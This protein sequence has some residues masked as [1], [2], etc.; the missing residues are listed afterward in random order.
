[1]FSYVSLNT[2]GLR[3]FVKRKSIF[4]FC[5]NERAQCFLLQETHSVDLDEKFWSNQWGDKIIFSHGSNRSAGVAILLNHFPGKILATVRDTCGHW[6]ICVFEIDNHFL[7]LGNIYG[8]NTLNQ[9]KILI[10]EIT[11]V[12]KDLCQRYPTEHL[13]FGGDFNMVMDNWLDRCPSKYSSHH[14]NPLLLGFCSVFK[15]TDIWRTKNP[16]TQIFTWFKP[17]R[18]VKSRIDFWLVSEF[19]SCLELSSIVSAAPLTDHCMVKLV[20]KPVNTYQRTKGYWKFNSNLLNNE[21]FCQD[22]IATISNVIEDSSFTT[23]SKKWEYIKYKVRQISIFYG[24]LLSRNRGKKELEIIKEIN[25]TC[26][27]PLLSEDEKQKIILLQSS[28]DNIFVDKAK[29]AFIRSRAKWI[30]EGERSSTYFCRLEK[31]RQERMSVKALLINNQECTDPNKI[32]KEIFEFY[33]KLY[34]SSYSDTDTDA[35]FYHIK[36]WIPKIDER[37]KD[38]CDADISMDEVEK[39]MKCLPLDKSPGS[40]GLTS[41]FYRHFWEHIKD[42]IFHMLKEISELHI[43]PT[44]MKQ[45]IITL[46]P[47]P[48]KNPKLID[49]LR[50]ITLL[51][52]DYKI[53]THIYANRL[54]TG[55]SQIISETQSGFLKG[56]SIHNNIRLVLDL[57]D[58]S[59]FIEDDGFILF[60]DFFKA[61]DTIEHTFMFRTLELFG[62][63]DNF[64]NMVKLIYKDTNSTV[65][66]PMGT[67]PR[68]SVNKGIKQGCPISPLLFIAAAEMLSILIKNL[69]FEKL[70]VLGKPLAISQLADDTTIFMKNINQIPKILQTIELFS[71]ASGLNLNLKKCE[72]LPIHNSPHSSFC[73]IPIKNTVKYLGIHITKDYNSLS[74]LNICD[75][76]VKCKSLLNLWSQRDISIIGRIFLTKMECIS[77]LVYPAYSLPFSKNE[78]KAINQ[79]IFNFI[80]KGKTHYIRK[81]NLVKDVEEGGLKA[82]DIECINATIKTNWL[83]SFLKNENSF[84]F[85][86]PSQVFLKLGGINLLLRC[87]Y[88]LKKLPVKLSVFH[89]QVLLYWKLIYKH[90]FSPHNVPLWNCRYVVFRNKSIFYKSWWEKGIWSVMHI[91]NNSGVMSFETFCSKYNLYDKKLYDNMIKA[92]P[93]SI[94]QMSQTLSQSDVTPVLPKLLVNGVSLTNLILPNTIIRDAFVK[95]LYPFYLSKQ[96]IFKYFSKTEIKILRTKYFKFPLAPKA[97]EVHFKIINGIYPSREFLSCRFGLEV[98]NCSFCT[99]QIETTDHIFFDCIYACA[100]W[101]DFHYWLFP[102]FEDLP[103]FNKE[104]VLFGIFVKDGTHDF[105]INSLIILGKFFI[106]KNRFQRTIPRFRIFHKELCNYFSSLKLMKKKSAMNLCY[107]VETLNLT[108]NP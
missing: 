20:L 64:I 47:K 56:R 51:N 94:F 30:E 48:G 37:F 74:T 80:W 36:D 1:M 52:N 38:V 81:G 8:Y 10:D 97:K 42:L 88:D 41:N 50:P 28:L 19:R 107:L 83:R 70:I 24:K 66:L 75:N 102:K 15:L 77:R 99:D 31:K 89:Q 43:L 69:D 95:E 44:T 91:L 72:L 60:L 40:D 29:G 3:D 65:I 54:K 98:N 59:H 22:V 103:V 34:S 87:D 45:G 35:F 11:N 79:A 9:N 17:D 6:L 96:L 5:K 101:E 85:Y 76:L 105:A 26:V 7:I 12:V 78:I 73:N 13:I 71:K 104:N 23:Y 55:I 21:P 86:I 68:F 82:I 67:S 57:L 4:L 90:N 61:F 49:N 2:R 93:L 63:G 25:S 46:I 106:H 108:E 27:K 39:A 62:L 32:S 16:T 14:Y 33:S 58:Y 53:L 18:S 84:W 100:F 92:I